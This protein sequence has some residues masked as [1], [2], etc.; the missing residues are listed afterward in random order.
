MLLMYI[1][2]RGQARWACL[3]GR[4]TFCVLDEWDLSLAFTCCFSSWL[5]REEWEGIWSFEVFWVL[6]SETTNSMSHSWKGGNESFIIKMW[7]KL[8]WSSEW[9]VFLKSVFT[10]FREILDW[11][12]EWYIIKNGYKNGLSGIRHAHNC[13]L[14]PLCHKATVKPSS[15][16]KKS[17]IRYFH[18][19]VE[20]YN[21]GSRD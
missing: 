18:C 10:H 21:P 17:K 5:E 4:P 19:R 13:N 9:Q 11:V 1:E 6:T 7:G 2:V 14:S 12:A 8:R 3:K 16:N 15:T 20:P